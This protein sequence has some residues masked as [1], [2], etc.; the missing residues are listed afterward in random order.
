MYRLFL[1]IGR[2]LLNE[3]RR[4]FL[5][6][7]K[8]RLLFLKN[9]KGNAMN[10]KNKRIRIVSPIRRRLHGSL[11]ERSYTTWY[12]LSAISVDLLVLTRCSIAGQSMVQTHV[13]A[14]KRSS[15]FP[16]AL[17]WIFKQPRKSC[18]WHHMPLMKATCI[19]PI[20]SALAGCQGT[21]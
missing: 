20:C 16:V 21:Q 15:H 18:S 4:L 19:V 2:M 3:Y 5:K 13:Q 14:S 9:S 6:K 17:I 8:Q 1:C 12:E 10:L 11:W 7:I